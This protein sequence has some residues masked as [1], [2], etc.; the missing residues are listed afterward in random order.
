MLR[1]D[2]QNPDILSHDS[3]FTCRNSNLAPQNT[4]QRRCRFNQFAEFL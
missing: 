4:N 1:K 2:G 3:L